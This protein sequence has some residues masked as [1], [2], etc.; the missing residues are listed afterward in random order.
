M[1]TIFSKSERKTKNQVKKPIESRDEKRIYNESMVNNI[2]R[3][4]KGLIST[5][6]TPSGSHYCG[7]GG[8]H[9]TEITK[10]SHEHY[11]AL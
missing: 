1:K 9:Q 3:Y 7:Y 4:T 6:E 2:S 10:K 5:S 8:L 11:L